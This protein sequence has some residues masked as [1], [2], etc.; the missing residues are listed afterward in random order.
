VV[1]AGTGDPL[2][3]ARVML[4]D[5]SAGAMTKIDGTFRLTKIPA[6]TY[7]L[8]INYI[9]YATTEVKGVEVKPGEVFKINVSLNEEAV[10]TEEVVVQAR[11]YQNT[12]AA[13]L[14]ERQ[15]AEAFSD[16]ISAEDIG[17]GGSG[18]AADAIKKVTG[19]TTVGGKHV[20]IRG[21]G[22]R[23]SST[24]LNGANLPTADPDKKSVHLDMFPSNLIENITTIKTATPD[25]PGDFTGGTVDIRT[26]SFPDKFKMKYS[27][28]TA[29]NT[30]TTGNDFLTYPGSGTD[31]L[32]YDNGKRDIPEAISKVINNPDDHIPLP[33][34]AYQKANPEATKAAYRLQELSR[35]FDPVMHPTTKAAPMNRSFSFSIGDNLFE[36]KFGYLA[37]VSYKRSFTSYSG[38][39]HAIYLLPGKMT[40]SSRL[41]NEVKVRDNKSDDEVIWGSMLNLA[42]N[43]STNH[44]VGV[45]FMFN[46]S[47]ISS[48]RYQDGWDRYYDARYETRVLQFTERN[49]RSLQFNGKHNFDFMSNVKMNWNVSYSNS[50]QYE[51]DLRF[52]TNDYIV[53][54]ADTTYEI[55]ASLYKYPSRYFRDL[56]ED[57]TSAQADFEIPFKEI[58]D[59]PLE[60]KAGFAYNMR[61]RDFR[62]HRFDIEQDW[63][64]LQYNGDPNGFF[65]EYTG[66]VDSSGYF[67]RFGNIISYYNP[68]SSSYSGEQEIAAAY[69]MI[70]WQVYELLRVV[71]GL[72]YETTRMDVWRTQKNG[73]SLIDESDLLPSVNLIYTLSENMNMRAAFGKTIARPMFR[74]VAPYSSFE[75]VGG[76]IL[77]GNPELERTMIDNYDLRWEWFQNPGEIMAVSTFYKDFENPIERTIINVND[78]VMYKNVAQAKL[79]GAEF[80]F[81]KKLGFI[82]E[83]FND[84]LFGVNFT[85]VFSE[86]DIPEEEMRE[87]LEFDPNA[88][89]TRELQ[90][91]S[92]YI[93]NLDL[94]YVNWDSGTEANLHYYVFGKR[95]SE[96][97][98]QGTP[99]IY[100]Y[101]RPDLN[102]VVSQKFFDRLKIKLT[103]KNILNSNYEKAQEFNGEKYITQSFELGTIYKI[104]ISYAI[105]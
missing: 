59:F 71:G 5:K 11:A 56:N 97:T 90:G 87:I 42:Y 15:K 63:S 100:E 101:P 75:Y 60:V 25:K 93:L 39:T 2:I 26:K 18:D 23:Y 1:D 104:G 74:E 80:E 92:P 37:S 32:G 66:I 9:G 88:S 49:M 95:L 58:N 91:Q 68:D 77:L 28:S 29:Y 64:N 102:L 61:G 19:A 38:G 40:D 14:K 105:D 82:N 53:D 96:V 46:Q 4:K 51:P 55:D 67:Y 7:S 41:V 20:Y 48:A 12:E 8:E 99:N 84:I 21:L 65:E 22:D 78:E 17:R 70:D 24:Q 73:N 13:L 43:V 89:R 79:F 81:R 36:Q 52:F 72:R 86:V 16:A 27:M 69:G 94:S 85:Y 10:M 83:I 3:G 31:W 57:V 76:Y 45:N 6:G 44:Q 50:T 62:E 34:E 54:D 103:A 47:G 98:Q 30:E 35:A 33:E